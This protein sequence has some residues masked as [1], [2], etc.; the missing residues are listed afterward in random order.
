MADP[1][2][3]SS[4]NGARLRLEKEKYNLN[5]KIR[6]TVRERFEAEKRGRKQVDRINEHNKKAT[7]TA[8]NNSQRD[9]QKI[10]ELTLQNI[11]QVNKLNKDKLA[12]LADKTRTD[13][14]NSQ[15]RSLKQIHDFQR[16]N[17]EKFL[18]VTSKAEDP[19]YRPKHF[20]TEIQEEEEHY[21][22]KISLPPYEARNVGVSG[23]SNQLKISF[24]RNYEAST[25]VSPSQENSTQAHESVTETYY[26][27]TNLNFKKVLREYREGALFIKIAK[28]NPLQFNPGES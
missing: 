9:L 21:D 14:E 8:L 6:D 10:K 18:D 28:A 3:G 16:A 24:S 19:F 17:M 7:E 13:F 22:I 5:S 26:M 23:F 11:D 1:I 2:D 12:R 20:T 4:L 27:P 25:P 15:V